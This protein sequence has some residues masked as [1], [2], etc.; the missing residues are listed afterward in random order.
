MFI[1][2]NGLGKSTIL[3]AIGLLNVAMTDRVDAS[4]I[5]RRKIGR[6]IIGIDERGRWRMLLRLFMGI[7][8]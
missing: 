4:W 7:G 6:G 8:L 3:E 2:A 1:G 5:K